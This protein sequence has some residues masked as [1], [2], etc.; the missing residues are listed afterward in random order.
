MNAPLKVPELRSVTPANRD[1]D[2]FLSR[3]FGAS[4]D[5]EREFQPHALAIQETPPSPFTRIV[6]WALAVL[7]AAVL[8]WAWISTIPISTSV[9]AKFETE[10][11]TKVVQSLNSGTVVKILVE[12]G[13][14][15]RQGEP[16]VELDPMADRAALDS[17]SQSRAINHLQSG[18]IRAELSGQHGY[19]TVP[20][21]TPAMSALEAGVMRAD[22][23]HLH[24]QITSDRHQISEAQANL[25]AGQATLA[26]YTQHAALDRQQVTDAAPLVPEGAM[27][28]E[29]FN[30]LKAQDIQDAGKLAAQTQQVEQLQQAVNAAQA[31]LAIDQT[32]FAATQY[33]ALETTQ[34]KGYDIES[35]YV[36]AKRQYQLNWLRSPVDGTVQDLNVASLGTVVQPGQTLA[37][38]IPAHAPIIVEADLPAQSAG[39]VKVGQRVSIKVTAY[40]FEQYGTIPGHVTWVSPTAGTQSSI[41]KAPAGEEHQSGTPAPTQAPASTSGA[42]SGSDSG[43]APPPTLYYQV[44][45]RPE[46][47]WLSAD[48]AQHHLY[49]GMTATV[50]IHTGQRRVL[51]FFLDPIVKYLDN[52]LGVR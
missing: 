20:G 13:Q 52:G 14:A 30:Q 42:S 29:E 40:P 47:D 4:R 16:L 41:A 9:P 34:S 28:G 1:R 23:A 17:Q 45:V 21:A 35:Q 25:A 32:Q 15:V 19:A 24:S 33:Q 12:D 7:L 10:A 49:P 36:S 48:G 27:S 11:H 37:T 44:H 5:L 6:L 31:Q 3:L 43:S 50:D 2:P 26:E 18:R 8:V 39:F 51:D 22:L 46:R 38:V